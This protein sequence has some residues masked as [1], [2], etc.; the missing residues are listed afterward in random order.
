[1]A[2]A[3]FATLVASAT[4]S[5]APG[6]LDTTFGA[7][8][9]V[10]TSFSGSADMNALVV[11][12]DGKLVAAG[13][14]ASQSA[15]GLARYNTS[16]SLDST[17]GTGGTVSTPIG[18]DTYGA[19]ALVLQSDGKLVA[20][21]DAWKDTVDA[22]FAVIR[23]TANGSLDTAF[24][25]G[26]KVTTSFG[27]EEDDA[28]ALVVQPDGKLVAAGV[29]F[30]GVRWDFAL[31]RY[32]TD[33]SLD[34]TFGTGGK[35]VTAIGTDGTGASALVLQPDGKLVAA[36]TTTSDGS[37]Y[38]FTVVRY[39]T[40]GS[41][42]T[43]FGTGGE[44]TTPIG[45][46]DNGVSALVRQSDGKLVAA[47]YATVSGTYDLA[48]VRYN[49]DGSLDSTF[50]TGGKVTTPVGSAGDYV[51]ALVFQSDGKLV[52]AGNTEASTRD[53]VVVRY[54]ATGTLD[55]TFG[56]GGKVTTA[57]G[58]GDDVAFALALQPDGNLV[59][60]GYA[61]NAGTDA[62]A[63]VRYLGQVCGDAVVASP[64]Q[65]DAGT[66]N[67]TA[68]SCC[69]ATCQFATTATPCTGGLCDSTG[70]CVLTTTTTSTS[71]TTT[72]TTTTSTTT[73]TASPTT[74]ST[75][76]STTSTTSTTTAVTTTTTAS[77]TTTTTTTSTT[78][79]SAPTTTTTSTTSTTSTT[80]A[81]TTTTTASPTTT[82]TTTS[83]TTNSAPTTSTSTT[84]TA[85]TT[86]AVTTSTT[87]AP[88]TTTVTTTSTTTSQPTTTTSSSSTSTTATSTTTSTTTVPDPTTTSTSAPES[89]TTSTTSSTTTVVPVTTTSASS[90]TMVS[91]TT[92]TS[93]TT[94][95][96]DSPTT[97]LPCP[98][99]GLDG[100]ACV[101]RKA[102]HAPDCAADVVP[103]AIA[104]R[105]DQTSALIERAAA[106]SSAAKQRKFVRQAATLL[107][108]AA[109]LADVA[110]KRG[111]ISGACS[112]TLA[113]LLAD[114]GTRAAGI[115]VTR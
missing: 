30:N 18:I 41:L 106:A 53:F 17:F 105:V 49:T 37:T 94:V 90:T 39:N 58:T 62:F 81:V 75:T 109:H 34:T 42:D 101:L 96:R 57:V 71:T 51:N 12:P 14:D 36:G 73:T 50:G 85:S 6:S 38:D 68:S 107:K 20:A 1:M 10:T 95:R 66:A 102:A 100:V 113:R 79:S 47:G 33:G 65:C 112:E 40:N 2:V 8:G 59:A 88:T 4:S 61:A 111:K 32:N 48:L 80:T 83:T 84:S 35:V 28:Y 21:G 54:N 44:V 82:T 46:G 72:T 16:G 23:Y 97:T 3:L 93:T 70:H 115:A 87:T 5:A 45:T 114:A 64:E 67:G 69:T 26:G 55:T 43:T 110:G 78:T 13:W 76:T 24:G 52:A 89:T 63:L 25:T 92:T 99:G 31:A 56:T 19:S 77:P 15:F 22:D 7:G 103:A 9:K 27:S 98:D 104:R 91:T 74:T 108:K 60:G 29:V 11:Q 86:T